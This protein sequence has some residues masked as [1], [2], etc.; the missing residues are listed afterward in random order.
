MII[1]YIKHLYLKITGKRIDYDVYLTTKHWKKVSEK[2]KKRAKNKCSICGYKSNL[3]VH[4]NSYNLYH[5]SKSDLV[6]LCGRCHTLVHS[7]I[8]K[9][10]QDRKVG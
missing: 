7:Y 2:A 1:D 4:H 6:C 5:E 3:V 10:K 9:P 8:W